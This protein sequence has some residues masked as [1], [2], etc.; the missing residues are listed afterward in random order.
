MLSQAGLKRAKG[1]AALIP[2]DKGVDPASLPTG[3]VT[4]LTRDR[5]IG[6]ARRVG[7]LPSRKQRVLYIWLI[8]LPGHAQ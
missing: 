4:G 7:G 1:N 8:D 5:A 6:D 2:E 3:S